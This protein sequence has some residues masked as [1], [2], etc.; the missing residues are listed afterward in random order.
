V[1]VCLLVAGVAL[2]HADTLAQNAPPSSDPVARQAGT[3]QPNPPRL[4]TFQ[5]AAQAQADQPTTLAPI[6]PGAGITGFDATNARKK[7][8][9]K[10]S[11]KPAADLRLGPA[12]AQS[13]PNAPPAAEPVSPYQ[14][15]IP[16]LP[17][18]DLAHGSVDLSNSALPPRP[19]AP[20]VDIGPIR[21]PPKK[22]NAHP[23]VPEDPY[24]PLGVRAG[25]FDLFP[26]VDLIGGYNTNPGA[27]P[28]GGKSAWLYTVMPEL[29]VNSNW[30]RHELKAELRG[31]YTGYSPDQEPTL[32]RP[33]FNGKI[34]GRIDV[35]HDTK[36]NLESRLLV[37]TDNPGSPNLQAG[38]AKLPIYMT[39][40]GTA[41]ITQAFNRFELALKGDADR[42]VYQESTLT[43]GS[44]VSN[45]DRNYDQIAGAL[46]GSY[47]LLPG[48]K[49]FVEVETDSRVHDLATD[50]FGFQRDS[51][52]V[53]VTAGTSL[54]LTRW[55]TGE[56]AVGETRRV[57]D[58][59]RFAALTGLIGNGSLLWTA[60]A[61]TTV[62][63]TATSTVGESAVP[64][65][66]G[67]LYR[68][69]GVQIDHAFRRWLIGSVK[70][71]FGTDDYVGIDR[72][73]TRY[74]AGLGLTYKVNRSV[75]IKGEFRQDWLR[76]NQPGNDY[77]ASAFLVGLRLQ[78]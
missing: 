46:R 21:K 55:L 25:A 4:R 10:R 1:R 68:D 63:V 14:R 9:P 53:T 39:F 6:P 56:I 20:P 77:T 45:D 11:A 32:S 38:L 36:I 29:L 35:T 19:G 60:S 49:P 64:D 5:P 12:L 59:P 15:P 47:E 54:S 17:T 72:I 76:S 13:D 7:I 8:K 44:T 66:S 75:Q 18:P 50:S 71:G 33:Y 28:G 51:R 57:Y 70:A 73:D 40:G 78:E 74:S 67:V 24:A 31:S 48:V 42:T 26:A 61:L 27:T 16:P 69:V 37:S 65:V 22:R 52:G 34:D 62:K 30:S 2:S 41:G 58:D 23:D 3:D 43:D